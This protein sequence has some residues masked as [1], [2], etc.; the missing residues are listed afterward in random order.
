V[1]APEAWQYSRGAGIKV[2]VVDTGIQKD[3]PDLAANIAGGRNF[4][5]MGGSVDKTKWNDDNGHG[6][7]VSGTI[8]AIDNS[9]GVVGVAPLAKIYAVKVLDRNGSGYLSDVAAG[10]RECVIAGA[11]VISMSLGSSGDS[12]VLHDAVIYAKNAG[13][14]IVAAAG[15]E[16]GPVL[17]PAKYSEVW[18]I[19]AVDKNLKFA[20]FSN[21]GPE[22]DFAA[23]GVTVYSTVK[24]SGYAY[25]SGTSM[26]TPHV[27][28]IV[29]LALSAQTN[30]VV[31]QTING[32]ST[33]QQGYGFANAYL[34]VKP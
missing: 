20:S 14:V 21:F 32:L 34:S 11:H 16:S 27:A 13:K 18:A 19:S 23:P 2:C 25:F 24:G 15:N 6:T 3:H 26:A 10:I 8:A 5:R 9:I 28:G 33:D 4:V 31:S 1:Q 7:H 29:A 12:S 17:Y 30:H 22:V